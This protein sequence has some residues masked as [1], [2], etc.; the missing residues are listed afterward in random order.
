MPSRPLQAVQARATES[1]ASPRWGHDSVKG[2]AYAT[3][4]VVLRLECT[5]LL[6][7]DRPSYLPRIRCL[8]LALLVV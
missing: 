1:S 6:E 8:A 4:V 2:L 5:A 3:D 7:R